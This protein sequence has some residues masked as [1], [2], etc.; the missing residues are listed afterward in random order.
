MTVTGFVI[1]VAVGTMETVNYTG[2]SGNNDAATVT[3]IW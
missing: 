1:P 2:G 3:A